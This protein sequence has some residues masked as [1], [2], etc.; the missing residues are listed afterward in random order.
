[1]S[2]LEAHR[3]R[4]RDK[5]GLG[6][7]GNGTDLGFFCHPTIVVNPL[8]GG[9]MGAVD[10]RLMDRNRERDEEGQYKK[11]SKHAGQTVGIREKE[12]YRWIAGGIDA[13]GR[14]AGV[15]RVTVV[16]DREGDIYESFCLL[17]EAGVDFV[18][19]SNYDRRVQ[20]AAEGTERL[21]EWLEQTATAY[22]YR[23]EVKGDQRGRKKREA[24]LAVKY[25]KARLKRPQPIGGGAKHYPREQE[26]YVVQAQEQAATI[27]AGEK[28]IAWRLYTS[29]EVACREA[30]EKILGYYQKRWI[31]EDLFRTLKSEGINYEAS[32]LERGKGL[33]KLFVLAFMAAIQILQL[34]Q[35]RDGQ[36][37]QA[38][39]L[40]FSEE[41]AECLEDLLPKFE[42]KTEKQKNPWPSHNLA[43]A[44]WIV[45][46]LGGWKGYQSQ[47]PPGVITL[48]EGLTRFHDIFQGWLLARNVYKR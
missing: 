13:K 30:A 43:W 22:E 26:V 42:G 29:H 47:R 8:D 12:S 25:G 10:I 44:S 27:P 46:R 32:E 2:N 20:G 23:L 3:E 34:R 1:V 17:G 5:A 39:S 37:E 28:G 40:V 24:L 6:E 11:K 18:I 4:I 14:L 16:Q 15:Q 45:G 33:R 31:I 7:V 41:Q 36:T 35:A 48:H 21:G 19:R 38:T 9:L